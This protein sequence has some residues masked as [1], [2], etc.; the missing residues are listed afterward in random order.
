MRGCHH[1]SIALKNHCNLMEE[2]HEN[3]SANECR[4]FT[5]LTVP[6]I[7]AS[8]DALVSCDCCGVMAVW[9][10]NVHLILEKILYLKYWTVL[11]VILKKMLKMELN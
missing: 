2:L 9:K 1:E 11:R 8:P 10:L 5:S 4:F 7:G 3:F 6:Y